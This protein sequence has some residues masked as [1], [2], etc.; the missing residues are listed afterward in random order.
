[1]RDWDIE[2]FFPKHG[3]SLNRQ[4]NTSTLK[5]E[6]KMHR[7]SISEMS[8]PS[9]VAVSANIRKTIYQ[10]PNF[11]SSPSN[12]Q[13][14]KQNDYVG[15]IQLHNSRNNN[16]KDRQISAQHVD[17]K[18]PSTGSAQLRAAKTHT[19]STSSQ[20][21]S[22]NHKRQESD[23]KLPIN[24]V[25]GFRRENSDFFPLAKRHSAVLGERLA[26]SSSSNG[27][28]SNAAQLLQQRASAL[29]QRNSIFKPDPVD[30]K[31]KGN[32]KTVEKQNTNDSSSSTSSNK[33]TNE[34]MIKT[35]SSKP[36]WSSSLTS[37][38]LD[39]LRPRREKTESVIFL[40]SSAARQQL[41]TA[42][43]QL[44]QVKQ[45]PGTQ[46]KNKQTK[47]IFFSNIY[48]YSFCPLSFVLSILFVIN[49][50]YFI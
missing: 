10:S 14:K 15:N 41:I 19:N 47:N 35:T 17:R 29:F 2:K 20:N 40:Q 11:L 50:L 38:N 21:C 5:S 13:N 46:T 28:N 26:G 32:N 24:F 7:S 4:S 42:Q 31:V 12:N 23:S 43:Q 22:R 45:F 39:F 8:N 1:M 25:R 34:A 36:S 48:Y 18:S 49:F 9:A 44:Q 6:Q 3:S 37:R 27:N 33:S 30:N 16:L